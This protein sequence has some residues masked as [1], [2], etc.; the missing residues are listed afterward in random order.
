[1]PLVL[2]ATLS[3]VGDLTGAF[4]LGRLP[5]GTR[6]SQNVLS[7]EDLGKPGRLILV[8]RYDAGR[9]GALFGD[10]LRR[11]PSVFLWSLMVILACATARLFGL[12]ATWLTIVQFVPTVVLLAIAPLLAE[13]ALSEVGA[14]ANRNASGVATVLRLADR[15]GGELEHFDLTV[16]FTGAG[17]PLP[18]GMRAWLRRHSREL[19]PVATAVVCIEP[20]GHGTPHYATKEG[21]VFPA[22]FHSTLTAIC[23]EMETAAPYV[24]RR[25]SDAYAARIAGLP[26]IHVG[27]LGED[28][29]APESVDPDALA[30]TYD[31]V[32]ELIERIDE[33]IGPRLG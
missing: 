32:S 3:A 28:A 27:S 21:L 2:L 6:A 26:A 4:F 16:V 33:E 30:R 25:L 12:D 13:V 8:A 14:G 22:R 11:W 7:D 9:G 24:A 15:Y 1:V 31:F 18:L 19:D 23:A 5:F 20:A 10:R 29:S 17:D